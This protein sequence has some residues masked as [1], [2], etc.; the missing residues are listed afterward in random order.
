MMK[1]QPAAYHES[2]RPPKTEA[3]LASHIVTHWLT[4]HLYG[5]AIIITNHPH[6][7]AKLIRRRWISAMQ[8]LQQERT[9]TFDADQLL[10]LT[11]SI[12]RMQQMII[13]I[14]PPHEFP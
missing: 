1:E 4:R 7:I 12:T 10:S 9:A 11:H 2:K 8:R 13:T 6:D 14:D 5:K 3:A